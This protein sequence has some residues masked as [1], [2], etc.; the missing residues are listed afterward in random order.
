LVAILCIGL[1]LASGNNYPNNV[2]GR[3]VIKK[4]NAKAKVMVKLPVALILVSKIFKKKKKVVNEITHVSF[5][6]FSHIRNM[7]FI[8]Y[9]N[10]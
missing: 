8:T 10:Y 6:V 1:G 3:F 7:I 9:I 5:V 2:C 4:D